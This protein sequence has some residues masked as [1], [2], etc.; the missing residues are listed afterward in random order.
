MSFLLFPCSSWVT[1]WTLNTICW[2]ISPNLTPNGPRGS[3]DLSPDHPEK[4]KRRA[5]VNST[6][7]EGVSMIHRVPA[8]NR[9]Q[10]YSGWKGRTLSA[11]KSAGEVLE[12][13]VSAAV[14]G[15]G[16]EGQTSRYPECIPLRRR[17]G[18]GDWCTRADSQSS[19]LHLFSQFETVPETPRP[20]AADRLL[21]TREKVLF[22]FYSKQE[23][24]WLCLQYCFRKGENATILIKSRGISIVAFL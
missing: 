19:V 3:A 6:R 2:E 17:G 5:C 24:N 21:I 12:S 15:D 23:S 18:G 10:E 13:S 22:F 11:H 9:S 1:G 4:Q 8:K 20:E 7:R 16:H 14:W